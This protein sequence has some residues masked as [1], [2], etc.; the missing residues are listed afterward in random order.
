MGATVLDTLGHH[1]DLTAELD[2][3]TH[4]ITTC[5]PTDW[6]TINRLCARATQ[7]VRDINS[8]NTNLDRLETAIRTVGDPMLGFIAYV[9]YGPTVLPLN[10]RYEVRIIEA[11]GGYTV[12]GAVR[13]DITADQLTDTEQALWAE[14]LAPGGHAA[15]WGYD[16]RDYEVQVTAY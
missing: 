12:P 14:V 5:K 16:R 13:R 8:E 7:V 11:P 6:R 3:L 15:V 1:R 10:V 9:I 2:A 4:R